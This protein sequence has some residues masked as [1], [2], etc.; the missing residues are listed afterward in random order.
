MVVP[1]PQRLKLR[2]LALIALAAVSVLAITAPIA[3]AISKVHTQPQLVVK[4]VSSTPLSL[5]VG[6]SLT[7]SDQTKNAGKT[8]TKPSKTA[9][10][11]SVGTPS[12]PGVT[13]L[14]LRRV[15]RLRPGRVST[16]SLA[17]SLGP[18][19]N[20][21]VYHVI[22]CANYRPTP[23]RRKAK[24]SCLVAPTTVTTTVGA[25]TAKVPETPVSPAKEPLPLA[26]PCTPNS[27]SPVK[28][29]DVSQSQGSI[30]F[31]EVASSGVQFVFAKAD[32]GTFTDSQYATYKKAATGA[33][34]EFGAYQVFEP[35]QDPVA[36]ANKFLTDAALAA[37]NLIP[38]LDVETSGGLSPSALRQSVSSWLRTVQNALG[39]RPLI[40]TEKSIWDSDVE[41]GLGAEGYPL[42]VASW[43]APPPALP[44]EWSNWEFWQYSPNGK[45]PGISGPVDLDEFNGGTPCTIG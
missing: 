45:V 16:G 40:Y 30:N 12:G 26:A 9:Y 43:T 6:G 42:W 21:G 13:V 14:G 3:S 7:V 35:N 38:V 33:G 32:Q 10:L 22:A 31:T 18:S 15:P 27:G 25:V 28:G 39:V 1:R 2:H 23:K 34:L 29:I 20:A 41:A 44:T 17:V 24:N 37:G 8:T 5:P 19:I 11:L 4:R 36:Q